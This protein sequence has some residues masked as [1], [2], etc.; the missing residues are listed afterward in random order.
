[1]IAIAFA[2]TLAACSTQGT[3]ISSNSWTCSALAGE[4]FFKGYGTT[5]EQAF[6]SATNQCQLN[7]PDANM[8]TADPNRCTPPAGKK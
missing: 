2:A 4:L 5:R 1:L 6:E 8:C 3:E 7:A